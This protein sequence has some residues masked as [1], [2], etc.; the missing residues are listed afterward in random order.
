M[1]ARI[2]KSSASRAWLAVNNGVEWMFTN[3][4][5]RNNRGPDGINRGSVKASLFPFSAGAK[6]LHVHADVDHE[7]EEADGDLE[8]A[9]QTLRV[10]D[11]EDVMR[12]EAA[13]VA[14]LAGPSQHQ[15]LPPCQR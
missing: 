9:G 6:H 7:H 13:A 8:S 2:Q 1:F 5:Q 15:V 4:E 11:G 14:R 10:D 3:P 12:H